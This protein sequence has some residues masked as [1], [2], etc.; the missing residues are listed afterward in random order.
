MDQPII[1]Q[2]YIIEKR[3]AQSGFKMSEWTY[4]VLKDFPTELKGRNGNVR[5]RGWIDA[6]ELKHY[7]LLPMKEG[8][9]M[10]PL[11]AAVRKKIGKGVGDTV[12]IILY[13]DES[14][15]VIP[16]DILVCLM[17]SPKAYDFFVSLSESNQKYY[18]DWIEAAKKVETKAERIVKMIERLEN[19]LKFYDWVRE[20]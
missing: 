4:I 5:V 7:N 13:A 6:Y 20:E 14:P 17:D 3:I 15:L 9:M 8:G 16:D 10:L 12:H 1:D 18:I 2:H 19:G 11:K